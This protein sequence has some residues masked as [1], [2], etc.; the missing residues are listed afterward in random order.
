MKMKRGGSNEIKEEHR[1]NLS[2]D[3]AIRRWLVALLGDLL[4]PVAR[5]RHEAWT[6]HLDE[7]YFEGVEH[8]GAV[9]SNA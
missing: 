4:T 3:C 9:A 2:A 1:Q 6:P 7:R 5:L 8:V